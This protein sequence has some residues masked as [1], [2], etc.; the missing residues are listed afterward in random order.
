MAQHT[1]IPQQRTAA[2]RWPVAFGVGHRAIAGLSIRG[3]VRVIDETARVLA[4]LRDE[5]GTTVGISGMRPGWETTWAHAV[6]EAG[7]RLWAYCP[8]PW[9][10]SDWSGLQHRE[11]AS[12]LARADVVEYAGEQYS[13]ATLRRRAEMMV[14][15]ANVGVAC[16][17]NGRVNGETYRTLTHAV[18][19]LGRPV[20]WIDPDA[21]A[22]ELSVL[23]SERAWRQRLHLP[24]APDP[25]FDTAALAV[26]R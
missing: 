23:P 1:R 11:W 17:V 9:Q 8:G 22:G 5:R 14:A 20:V 19:R 6:L 12:L 4:K 15:A 13:V 2:D 25:L 26:A 7:L 10:A 21:P 3:K 24:A 16:W 18:G